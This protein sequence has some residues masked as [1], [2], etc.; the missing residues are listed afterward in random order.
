[1]RAT[2]AHMERVRELLGGKPITVSSAYRNP[3]VNAA[4]GGSATSD[5]MSGYSVDFSCPSFGTPFQIATAIRQSPIFND[6]DQLIHEFGR[7]VHVSFAP[8]RRHDDKTAQY[9]M[10][11]GGRKTRYTPG[12]H[13]LNSDGSMQ[14]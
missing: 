1:M 6:V 9:G 14:A 5:H 10:E 13:P 7:W 3:Q 8:E 4:V 11:G 2:A 12:V